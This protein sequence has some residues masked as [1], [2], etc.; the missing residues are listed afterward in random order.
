M[1]RDFRAELG[2]LADSFLACKLTFDDFQ[3]AYSRRF[4]DEM[5]DAAL[6]S[7]ELDYFGQIHEKAEWTSAAPPESDRKDGWLDIDEFKQWLAQHR[8]KPVSSK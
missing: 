6:S 5:P 2:E 1:T 4:I 3:A 7:E 8:R